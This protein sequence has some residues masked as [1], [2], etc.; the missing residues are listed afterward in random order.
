[1]EVESGAGAIRLDALAAF[2]LGAAPGW[3][4]GLALA[5]GFALLVGVANLARDLL[6][7]ARWRRD[8][9][10]LWD[11]LMLAEAVLCLVLL[12][13]AV[14]LGWALLSG[15]PGAGER[16]RREPGGAFTP[17]PRREPRAPE[18]LRCSV[19]RPRLYGLRGEIVDRATC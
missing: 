5:I 12:L 4:Q 18:A 3:Q 15:L 17:E 6:A 8:R 2:G 9:V 10:R 13:V 16:P 19:S 11:S 14:L 7:A 1:M